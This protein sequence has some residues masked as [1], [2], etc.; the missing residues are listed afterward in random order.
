[1]ITRKRM[2]LT[3]PGPTRLLQKGPWSWKDWVE[4][5]LSGVHGC[6]LPV[7]NWKSSG[8]PSLDKEPYE[9]AQ[10]LGVAQSRTQLKQ[11]SS[12]SCSK[13]KRG[14]P[15]WHSG[16]ESAC[17]CRRC[18]RHGFNPWVGKIP[19]RRKWQPTPIF[20]PGEFHGQRSLAG[21]SSWGCKE[22]DTTKHK[23]K[24]AQT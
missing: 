18:K 6:Q 21:Y 10:M 4:G 14:L 17:Q 22:L 5:P 9:K 12:S 20:L 15:R 8:C 19:L 3:L 24:Q 11:F 7:I 1:M 13:H 23:Y 16:E 2:K